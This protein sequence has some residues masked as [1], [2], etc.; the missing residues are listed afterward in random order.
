MARGIPEPERKI[1]AQKADAIIELLAKLAVIYWRPD[2]TMSQLREMYSQY[3][4]AIEQF[5]FKD[6][7]AAIEKWR[8]DGANK[9]FPTPGELRSLIATPPSWW[10]SGRNEWMAELRDDSTKEIQTALSHAPAAMLE[11]KP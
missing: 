3:L 6:I 2:F 4:D 11:D 10:C 7:A 9:F 5:A 8:N 1:R